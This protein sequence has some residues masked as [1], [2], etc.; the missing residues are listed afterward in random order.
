MS[1]FRKDIVSGDW[2]VVAP[3]RSKR[4]HGP[5]KR[6]KRVP[7]PK[8]DCPFEHHEE[9]GNWPPIHRWPEKGDWKVLLVP[10][11]FPALRHDAVCAVPAREGV[12]ERVDGVGW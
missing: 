10:N 6:V 3:E 12:R 2:V 8:R 11:K 7:S 5:H 9:T 4:P 1:E